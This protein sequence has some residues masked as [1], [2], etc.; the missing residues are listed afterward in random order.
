MHFRSY[1]KQTTEKLNFLLLSNLN[2][3]VLRNKLSLWKVMFGMPS[4]D[5]RALHN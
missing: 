2:N 5:K 1:V 3:L 4:L